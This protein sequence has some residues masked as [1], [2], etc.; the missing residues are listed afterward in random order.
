[1]LHIEDLLCFQQ[2]NVVQLTDT[3]HDDLMVWTA[4]AAWNPW[5]YNVLDQGFLSKRNDIL[6]DT[7][8]R[9][10]WS[11][12]PEISCGSIAP[13]TTCVVYQLDEP[14]PVLVASQVPVLS[15]IPHDHWTLQLQY[16]KLLE[17]NYDTADMK[18]DN[19]LL[20]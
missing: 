18:N 4:P 15:V 13:Y 16:H 20:Y 5:W 14:L 12:S 6:F 3:L 19:R 7:Y 9:N 1:M 2:L 11:L 8:V 17:L 10:I